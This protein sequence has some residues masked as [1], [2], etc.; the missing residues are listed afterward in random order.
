MML[1]A[2]NQTSMATA[3]RRSQPCTAPRALSVRVAAVAK[4]NQEASSSDRLKVDRRQSLLGL[5]SVA[6]AAAFV[7]Q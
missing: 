4:P 1:K 2:G 6:A 7:P 5:A 3:T